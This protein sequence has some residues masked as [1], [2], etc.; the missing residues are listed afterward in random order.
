MMRSFD[1]NEVGASSAGV[2]P[3]LERFADQTNADVENEGGTNEMVMGEVRLV[4]WIGTGI[5]SSNF[6]S[7][8]SAERPERPR[9]FA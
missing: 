4:E 7:T 1:A 3:D 6:P 9:R 2:Q 8:A 5:P